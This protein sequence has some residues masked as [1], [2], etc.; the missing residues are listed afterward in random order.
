VCELVKGKRSSDKTVRT[1]NGYRFI[2]K[3]ISNDEFTNEFDIDD[4]A[5]FI[6]SAFNGNG[7]CRLQYFE[8]KCAYSNLL[9]R[10][11][12]DETCL[13]KYLY[14][15]IENVYM[16]YIQTGC[17]KGAA[18]KSLDKDLFN[19]LKIPIPPIET[20][21]EI[22]K[23]CDKYDLDILVAGAMG[24]SL[25]SNIQVLYTSFVKPM[26]QNSEVKTLGEVCEISVGKM[27]TNSSNNDGK[28]PFYTGAYDN[29]SHK[30]NEYCFDAESY[31]IL[32]KDGGSGKNI[33][34]TNIGLGMTYLVSGKSAAT[35]SQLMILPITND[36][37][38][39][40]VYYILRSNKNN[41]MDLARYGA[42]ASLGHI[43][44]NSI[45][46]FKIPVPSIAM[47]REII[48]KY[49]QLYN[50]TNDFNEMKQ[51]I[52]KQK[53]DYLKSLFNCESPSV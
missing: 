33:Y 22:I 1:E 41:I 13:P 12:P 14:H 38:L 11:I 48:K 47:Q 24:K 18:N 31:I 29:P 36:V 2:T 17:V 50:L 32:T 30:H 16:N 9:Y 37:M 21:E 26:L 4:S 10:I 15:Y 44:I 5:V 39:L 43:S 46:D 19:A 45:K 20:Q 8:G 7:K 34:K 27:T 35:S 6:Y 52:E 23:Q 51:V 25:D 49:D 53:E 40:Y 42:N 28:Y 3:N